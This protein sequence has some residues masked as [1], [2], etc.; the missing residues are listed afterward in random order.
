[1]GGAHR[2][3]R[4]ARRLGRSIVYLRQIQFQLFCSRDRDLFDRLNAR[5]QA[6]HTGVHTSPYERRAFYDTLTI[7]AR[8]RD[9]GRIV[10]HI[11]EH[12]IA[13][14]MCQCLIANCVRDINQGVIGKHQMSPLIAFATSW[15]IDNSRTRVRRSCIGSCGSCGKDRPLLSVRRP[16]TQAF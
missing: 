4:W 10:I 16:E 2:V 14:K 1:M 7:N 15:D 11:E 13:D 6:H 12:V 3:E 8:Q 9:D 5:C